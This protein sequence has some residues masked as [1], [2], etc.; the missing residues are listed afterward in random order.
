V[1]SGSPCD[2]QNDCT[3]D[4]CNEADDSCGS[5]CN[6]ANWHDACCADAA[7]S[8]EPVCE[9]PVGCP[10]LDGDGYGSPA[11]PECTYPVLEDCADDPSADAPGCASCTCD[12]DPACAGCARCIHPGALE[13]SGDAFDTNCNNNQDCF[14]AT[15]SFGTEMS[16]KIDLL[17]HF[18]DRVLL[19]SGT[20]SALVDA[21]YRISPPIA[22]F[23]RERP[24]LRTGVRLLLLP[25]VGLLSLVL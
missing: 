24:V 6:A 3:D 19:S 12:T 13:F 8:G 20:G 15:A 9:Q 2:D 1:S 18:R 4:T 14:I 22:D 21:Y 11:H 5:A 16:G 7:C 10:D 25:V 17:R 23:I